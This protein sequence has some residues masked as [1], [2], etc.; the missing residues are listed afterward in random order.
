MLKKNL[1]GHIASAHNNI[2]Y[3]CTLCEKSFLRNDYLRDHGLSVH[4]KTT[5]VTCSKCGK[6]F[7]RVYSMRR[8]Q[9]ICCKCK[10]CS[11][12]FKN[13]SS[14]K[15]HSCS[16]IEEV[17]N[18]SPDK[19][20]NFTNLD[21]SEAVSR[22]V[23][24]SPSRNGFEAGSTRNEQATSS[25]DGV[26]ADSTRNEQTTSSKVNKQSKR[27]SL[28]IKRRAH[29][30]EDEAAVPVECPAAKKKSKHQIMQE[31][32]EIE[33]SDSNLKEFVKKY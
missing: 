9:K 24:I 5:D 7:A 27:K 14:L 25:R 4:D 22:N 30:I 20:T 11:K 28:K 2:K 23:Q 12:Q 16:K 15:E 33:E 3:V 21:I 1:T 6:T 18:L 17:P 10:Q 29:Q 13:V 19:E 8:H 31:D 26:E 32:E